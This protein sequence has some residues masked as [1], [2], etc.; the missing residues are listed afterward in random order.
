[1]PYLTAADLRLVLPDAGTAA[2]ATADDTALTAIIARASEVVDAYCGRTWETAGESATARIFYG[3]GTPKLR[4][5]W[6]ATTINAAAVALPSGWT[7]PAFVEQRNEAAGTLYAQIVDSEGWMIPSTVDYYPYVWPEG[8][9]ITV[10]ATWGYATYPG[11][12]IE[13][14]AIIAT[15]RWRE[16]YVGALEDWQC[17]VGRTFEIPPNARE[18][19]NRLRLDTQFTVGGLF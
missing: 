10:T 8:M 15:A 3:T 7:E 6:T 2:D 17:D 16:T 1:M 14:T 11:D 5:D 9:P 13:A 19:L 4:L 12:V 18:I